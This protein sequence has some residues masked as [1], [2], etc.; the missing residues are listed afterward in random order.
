ML[1]LTVHDALICDITRHHFYKGWLGIKDGRFLYVEPGDVP[2]GVE[3]SKTVDANGKYV[4]PGFVDAHMHIESSLVTPRRFAEAVLPFGTTT[5]LADPHEIAN[6]I[7]M[8]GVQWMIRVSEELPLRVYFAIPSCVPA[9]SPHVEWTSSIFNST[10]VSALADEPAIVALGEVM[11]YRKV[12]RLAGMIE[13]AEQAGLSL[14]GHIPDLRGMELSEYLSWGMSSNHSA[15]NIHDILEQLTKGI[16]VMLQEK[17]LTEEIMSTLR[18]LRDWSHIL[19][20]TDDIEPNL[21]IEGHLSSTVVNAIEAGMPL[22]EALASV[23]VRPA[24][25]LGLKRLGIIGPG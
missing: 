4:I 22:F 10:I 3:S 15:S 12:G 17:A 19:L 6:A 16:T 21:L 1:D 24:Q 5:I 14:E 13:T 20:V 7:G 18:G 8:R 23:T 9:T 2:A 25:Y 11:D